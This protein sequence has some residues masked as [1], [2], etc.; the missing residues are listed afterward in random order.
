MRREQLPEDVPLCYAAQREQVCPYTG[1]EVHTALILECLL[2]VVEL[3]KGAVL[4]LGVG[5][6]TVVVGR[7]LPR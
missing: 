3:S 4:S 2:G 1:F 7:L 5:A 6:R